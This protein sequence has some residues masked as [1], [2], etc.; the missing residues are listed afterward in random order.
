MKIAV[1]EEDKGKKDL[2]LKTK[3][4]YDGQVTL[5]DGPTL[6]FNK[7]KMTI[8]SKHATQLLKENSDFEE[9]K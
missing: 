6:I 5:T 1:K 2:E 3:A 8:S 7:G 4:I 9:V